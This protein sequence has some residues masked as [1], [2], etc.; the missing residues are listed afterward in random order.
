MNA[1]RKEGRKEGLLV[2]FVLLALFLYVCYVY[3]YNVANSLPFFS[4]FDPSAAHTLHVLAASALFH[5]IDPSLLFYF[6]YYYL[7]ICICTYLLF[8]P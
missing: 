5:S 4:L 2:W 8:N 3:M 7:Y 6:H 1:K